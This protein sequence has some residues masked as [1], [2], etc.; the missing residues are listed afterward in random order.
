[1]SVKMMVLHQGMRASFVL[2][3]YM[4]PMA[5]ANEPTNREIYHLVKIN[6]LIGAQNACEPISPL[7]DL[8][9][10]LHD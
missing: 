7:R 2:E 9:V 5:T 6:G 8:L 10:F 1:M 3:P 4:H